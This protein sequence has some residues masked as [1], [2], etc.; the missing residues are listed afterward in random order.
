MANAPQA[1]FRCDASPAIGAGHAAR[2]LA[3]AE[4]L[5]G[6][7]WKVDFAVGPETVETFP[8][9]ADPGIGIGI[10]AAGQAEREPDL[11]RD[12]HP[13]GV[14]LLVLDHYGRDAAFERRCRPWAR[15]ILVF[16][17]A[18]GRSHDCDILVD[19]AALEPAAY[20]GHVPEHA[21]VLTG[22]AYALL[23]RSFV[24]R[25]TAALARRDAGAV[26][27]ILI[28]FGASDPF[29]ATS[30]ALDVLKDIPVDVTVALS[31][32]APHLD[33]VQAR[34]SKRM[35]LMVDADL[36]PLTA[37]ADLAIGAPGSSAF[38]RALLGLP[39]ILVTLADNQ[40]GIARLLV[41][42]GAAIDAGMLDHDLAARLGRLTEMLMRDAAARASMS[43]A[44]MSL[45]DG[46]GAVRLSL[47][48]AGTVATPDQARVRLRLAEAGDEAWL[49]E[50]QR[51]PQTRQY[52]RNPTVPTADEHRRWLRQVLD[53]PR[54]LLLI[55]EVDATPAGTVRLDRNDDLGEVVRYAISIA[56]G[57]A[58]H[59]R[60]V[61]SAALSLIRRLMPAAALDAD[62]APEN[63]ASM[64]LFSSKGFQ[65]V[66]NDLYRSM[67]S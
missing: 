9:L 57:P 15:Q 31:S 5:V 41:R 58:F 54:R 29:N 60:G 48:G 39:S 3:F 7:G 63:V 4:Q 43:Q 6:L 32:R 20:R 12:H 62:V 21:L 25:R 24:T 11:L 38:E 44:A 40:R 1:V 42:A 19:A 47:A 67:P 36:A 61:G 10:V 30:I 37:E 56:I 52:F 45:V 59:N 49:L 8:A 53:D 34:L 23:R 35:R 28:S 27:N 16:D 50:L 13:Q 55:V 14:D 26:R 64:R 18:T 2:C 46:R 51:Q 17:D 66:G 22:P 33:V 65:R